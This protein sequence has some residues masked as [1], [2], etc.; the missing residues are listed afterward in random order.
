VT[1]WSA[2]VDHPWLVVLNSRNPWVVGIR[3]P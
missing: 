2:Q 3:L 1:S